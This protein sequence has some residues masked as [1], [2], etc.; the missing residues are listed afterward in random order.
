LRTYVFFIEVEQWRNV[1]N[2][3]GA[4]WNYNYCIGSIDGK[5]VNI[6]KPPNSGS[7]YYNYKGTFSIVQMAVVNANYQFL[8]VD[9]G[10]NGRVSDGGFLYYTRFWEK[11]QNNTL[12]IPSLS[13]LPKTAEEFPYVFVG[14]ETFFVNP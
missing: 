3:F 10:A 9:V 1:S 5:Y 6:K 12:N 14:D 4:K 11:F 8:M 13:C 2:D 7:L